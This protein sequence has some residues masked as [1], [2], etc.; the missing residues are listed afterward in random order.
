MDNS[1]KSS[2]EGDKVTW[3]LVLIEEDVV[4]CSIPGGERAR[5]RNISIVLGFDCSVC[6][7]QFHNAAQ[8][9]GR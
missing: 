2:R 8:A 6:T 1:A 4:R 3:L 9:A 7:G 5:R